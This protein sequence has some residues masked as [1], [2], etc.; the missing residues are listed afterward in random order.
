MSD[1]GGYNFQASF[2]FGPRQEGMVNIRATSPDELT[3][4]ADVAEQMAGPLMDLIGAYNPPKDEGE[5]ISNLEAGGITGEVYQGKV[6]AHGSMVYKAGQGARGP[7]SAW[8]CPAP[9]GDPT[10]CQP[11]DAKTGRSWPKR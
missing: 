11:V 7:W 6:C 1:D 5:A 10:K 4:W 2:K 8:M 3:A 9:Q